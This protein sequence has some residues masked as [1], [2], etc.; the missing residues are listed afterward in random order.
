MEAKVFQEHLE[1]DLIPFWNRMKDE[2]NGGF[3]GY[4]DAAREI[5]T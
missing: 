5:R 2:I 4:A 1:N 3:Y